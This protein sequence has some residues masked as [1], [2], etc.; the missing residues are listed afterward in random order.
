MNMRRLVSLFAI[1]SLLWHCGDNGQ[2]DSGSIPRLSAYIHFVPSQYYGIS[3][4]QFPSVRNKSVA[5]GESGRFVAE[6]RADGNTIPENFTSDYIRNFV[7]R[8][9][10]NSYISQSVFHSFPDSGI[11]DIA[12][13][14]IDFFNDT[15]RDTMTL[16]VNTPIVTIP[17][18]PEND[19][20]L[21]PLDSQ[22]VTFRIAT[23]GINSWQKVECILYVSEEKSLVRESPVS[24]IPCNGS[25]RIRG[26][27]MIGDS[28]DFRDTSY[29][30][31][32]AVFAHVP[33]SEN[34]FDMDSSEIRQFR[35]TLVGTENSR[36]TIPIRYKSLSP[37]ISPSG[38]V[39]LTNKSGDTLFRAAVTE[40]PSI[41]RFENLTAGDTLRIDVRDTVRSEYDGYSTEIFLPKST[42]A[43]LDTILLSDTIPP[44]RTPKHSRIGIGDSMAFF[45]YDGGS[46]ISPNSV[47][48]HLGTD[49]LARS[50][51]G[52]TVRFLPTCDSA[53]PLEISLRD[54]AG[55]SAAPVFWKLT[56]RGD[57][58]DVSGP[59][60]PGTP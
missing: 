12:L 1:V 35:T 36:L 15:L 39:V 8:I 24:E 7:W 32:W 21:N 43:H 40:N 48:I 50:I 59:F 25:F 29:V 2:I 28:A 38:T 6:I 10:G 26:P 3:Y 37:N 11:F 45:L 46:G 52:N 9:N 5:V 22:G 51:R 49:T 27:L 47:Q 44:L 60:N 53:C 17:E 55:N 56:R 33:G 4:G 16:F 13:E 41:V 57:G 54:Y 14:T 23:E 34:S 30:L 42:D 18:F 58:F 19:A 31:Y 20:S